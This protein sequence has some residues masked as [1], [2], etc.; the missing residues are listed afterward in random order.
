[1]TRLKTA[2]ARLLALL[3]ALLVPAAAVAET[4]AA[5]PRPAIWLLED[6]DTRIY[7][8]GTTHVFP[9]SLDWRSPALDRV[10]A[11]ADELVME[12]P[13][14][15]PDDM[16]SPEQMFAMMALGKSVPILDRV[17]P[18]VRP[19]LRAALEA[20][21]M[22]MEYFDGLHTWA[23]AF[24]LTGFA[25]VQGG[26]EQE[27]TEVADVRLSGAE[28]ELGTLFR[29]RKRPISGV[30]T[31][32]EQLGFFAS[33]PPT[34]QRR[35][36]EMTV[37]GTPGNDAQSSDDTRNAWVRGDVEAIAAEMATMPPEIYDVLLTRRNRAWTSWLERRLERPG[38]VLF[39]VGAGHLAGPES[40]QHMLAAR[41]LV[42]RRID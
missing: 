39:A 2:L 22:P 19:Q 5:P 10:I 35:F 17:S 26:A 41:G 29:S 36:L 25:I 30:E 27:G 34:A 24:L 42:A 21:Q 31:M 40:V 7:L 23:V 28:E 3:A 16:G 32:Q 8:F 18:E 20:T 4:R 33:L 37:T 12:T 11:Q 6:E 14:V 15:G 38:T 1:M 9:A 13:N